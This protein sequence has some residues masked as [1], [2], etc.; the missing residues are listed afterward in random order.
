MY[1][2]SGKPART[3]MRTLTSL[4]ALGLAASLLAQP[5]SFGPIERITAA[6]LKAHLE[7][8]A[9]DLL[10]G[11]D[12]PSRG[13]DI[14]AQYIASQCKLAGLKPAGDNGTYLQ[15][16]VLR[17]PVVNRA[18]TKLSIAGTDLQLGKDFGARATISGGGSSNLVFV[19]SGWVAPDWNLDPYK[20]V[21]VRGKIVVVFGNLPRGKTFRD[22]QGIS[23]R[24]GET[25]Q[26]ALAKRGAV[27]MVI[28]GKPDGTVSMPSDQPGRASMADA[29]QRRIPTFELGY[30]AAAS[31]LS[32]DPNWAKVDAAVKQD[33]GSAVNPVELSTTA[34]AQL[35]VDDNASS[36]SNVVAVAEGT[37]PK[38]KSEFVAIGAH[39]DHIGMSRSGDDRINNGAD[40]DGS[41]TVGLIEMAY[42][43]GTATPRRSLLFVWHGG[44]EQGL[45]GSDYFTRNPTVPL[46]S[47]VAQLNIDMI[48]RSA[49][50][51]RTYPESAPMT[52]GKSVHLIGETR[53]SKEFGLLV[54]DVNRKLYNLRYDDTHDKESDPQSLYSRSDH[55]NYAR[56]GIP[57][58]FWFDGIHEDYHRPSDEVDKIDFPKIERISRTVLATAFAVGNR[59]AR[60]RL[61]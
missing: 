24:K 58:A 57:V 25:P 11:R 23:Q 18:E 56:F 54:A 12:T 36:F 8:V 53:L 17:R 39:Y 14:A 2:I 16:I 47:I 4:S 35:T 49:T 7:F 26:E 27:A 43:A 52:D 38:L 44:E 60:P 59:T 13:L 50:P 51:G 32:K 3:G 42:A 9:H 45:W 29:S 37:D 19:D 20:L 22:V 5:S 1:G 33:G 28:L 31:A 10:E 61:D 41:G 21:D 30:A 46:K 34:T 6:R 40:D 48:G 15:K 55:Y